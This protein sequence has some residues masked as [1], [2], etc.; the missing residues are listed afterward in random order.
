MREMTY[1][2]EQKVSACLLE[3]LLFPLVRADDGAG[4]V[5]TDM[6]GW[7]ACRIVRRLTLGEEDALGADGDFAQTFLHSPSVENLGRV[8]RYARAASEGRLQTDG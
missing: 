2:Y 5:W 8:W 3:H 6:R 7:G 1:V 4:V